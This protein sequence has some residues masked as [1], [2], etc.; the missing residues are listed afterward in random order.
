M[1]T[2]TL[3]RLFVLLSLTAVVLMSL[4]ALATIRQ[5]Q[6]N[7]RVT[8]ASN[9]RYRSYLLADELRQSSDD[10]TRLA[11]TYVVTGDDK[12]EQQYFRVLDIRN[13]KTPRPQDYQRIYWDFLAADQP[14]PRP[15][16]RRI[17][18][19]NLM[20]QAGFT[21]AEFAKL[22]EAENNSNGLV[23][24][25][26]VAMN[27]V[28]G[29]YEDAQGNFSVRGEPDSARARELMHNLDYHREK[30]KIMT[31][32]DDF[33]VLL[34][35]RTRDNM[36]VA[37]QQAEQWLTILI[38]LIVAILAIFLV[39]L[40]LAYRQLRNTIGGE[41]ITVAQTLQRIAAGDIS[42]SLASAAPGSVI[43]CAE[44]MRQSLVK[45]IASA[46]FT[47]ET[48]SAAV[49]QLH[50]NSDESTHRV[51]QQEQD[52][53]MIADAMAQMVETLRHVVQTVQEVTELTLEADRQAQEGADT[54]VA[55]T[56]SIQRLSGE[57][58]Q[59]ADAMKTLETDSQSI[60]QVVDVI[61][62]IAE[63]TNLLAL[64]AAIEAARAGEQGRGFAVVADEV[65]TLASRTQ[66]S[67]HEIREMINKLQQSAQAA[68]Q[69]MNEG[70]NQVRDSAEQADRTRQTFTAISASVD[71]LGRRISDMANAAAQQ[72]N[73]AE[74][75]NNNINNIKGSI[76]HSTEDAHKLT[77]AAESLMSSVH[78]M[79]KDMRQFELPVAS[80]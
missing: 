60:Y 10:L 34:D 80:G 33:F 2:I 46:R 26:T 22:K 43:A 44:T 5:M 48:I 49:T 76:H 20:E 1:S 73:A 51:G 68:S 56:Q 24:T 79:L 63:Q 16:D 36:A 57:I 17:A 12:W 75:I 38:S 14:Q 69:A 67:T 54:V 7:Q 25:E 55:N 19:R 53:A 3:K 47:A 39:G 45:A 61:N 21:K 74:Q 42:Q 4:L 70:L 8:E 37:Q 72:E 41:P 35:E 29:L 27:A 58:E 23:H 32:V 9:N 50:A 31:P 30:A 66:S 52:A 40:W 13:G 62:G 15:N 18:L 11:R 64:N 28:K 65:R 71:T 59:I 78:S 6:V 77:H